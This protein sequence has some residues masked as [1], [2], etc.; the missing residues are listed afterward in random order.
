M[1]SISEAQ[2]IQELDSSSIDSAVFDGLLNSAD[3]QNFPDTKDFDFAADLV[4]FN[5]HIF[6]DMVPANNIV[7]VNSVD[8]QIAPALAPSDCM[9]LF[10]EFNESKIRFKNI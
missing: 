5:P 6:S 4:P 7:P 8:Q 1:A 3:F 2:I 9:L 10:L